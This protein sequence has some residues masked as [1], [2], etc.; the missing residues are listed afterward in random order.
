MLP[1]KEVAKM[2]MVSDYPAAQRQGD[3]AVSSDLGVNNLIY[4][5]PDALS[6]AKQ[7]TYIKSFFQ[8]DVYGSGAAGA[9][10]ETAVCDWNS[11]VN[12]VDCAN[13]Y[14]NI[15]VN[16]TSPT[17]GQAYTFGQGSV[18]NVIQSIV[19]RTRSGTEIERIDMAN[20]WSAFDI[21]YH[22]SQLWRDTIGSTMGIGD[23]THHLT[24]STGS[25]IDFVIPLS[26]LA[27]VFRPLKGQLMPPQLASGLHFEIVFAPTNTAFVKAA[28]D[29]SKY[30]V[31]NIHFMLDSVQMSDEVLK[32]INQESATN[33][34]E[35]VTPRI[36]TSLNSLAS[37]TKDIS[38]QINKSVSQCLGAFGIVQNTSR[39]TDQ[40]VD[41]LV[42][43]LSAT[44][45][46][47]WQYR[48]GSLF[49]PN[50][51]VSEASLFSRPLT[52]SQAMLWCDR[53]KH[54]AHECSVS[55]RDFMTD[56]GVLAFSANKSE[57]LYLAGLPVNNSRNLQLDFSFTGGDAERRVVV[58][59]EYI[60]VVRLW[61]TNAAVAI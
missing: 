17:F 43:D 9:A 21:R 38:I 52:Y 55:M 45:G 41:S 47:N 14:L 5:Q 57:E 27:T 19:I 44:G 23:N 31:S 42:S 56:D 22:K 25:T 36:H 15:A 60:Q 18:M 11:G 33:G 40:T 2:S 29:I 7:R 46:Y 58:F 28:G 32:T 30:E 16:C 39:V 53:Y 59:M 6:L 26:E 54:S 3:D 61:S 1:I 48:I 8:R 37:T 4:K 50:Q 20:L 13:S 49:F 24:Y 34:L 12:F 35:W 51:I 10:N